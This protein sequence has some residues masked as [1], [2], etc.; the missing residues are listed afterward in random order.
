MSRK[1]YE[2]RYVGYFVNNGELEE[3]VVR[4]YGG[5]EAY[6]EFAQF[7]MDCDDPTFTFT[8]IVRRVRDF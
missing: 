4:A 8:G 5:D 6:R 2:R 1:S 3:H 7:E